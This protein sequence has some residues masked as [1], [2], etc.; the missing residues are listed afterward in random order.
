[1]PL[2]VVGRQEEF[3]SITAF[4]DEVRDGPSA[5]VLVGE[6]GIGKSTLWRAGVEHARTRGFRV[7]SSRPAEAERSLAHVGLGDLCEDVLD[8]VLPAL[9]PPRRRALEFAMLRDETPGDPVDDRA[10]AV[11]VRDMLVLLG[12]QG[13]PSSPSTMFSGSIRPRRA[14]LRSRCGGFRRRLSSCC[15]RDVWSTGRS[16]PDSSRRSPPSVFA[17]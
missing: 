8:D 16:R 12:D 9:T 10:L 4:L 2:E 6:A 15:S 7:L 3:D 1:M 14:H 5:L 11:A 13:R 17:D